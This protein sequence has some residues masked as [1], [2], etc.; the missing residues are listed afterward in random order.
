MSGRSIV[1]VVSSAL[2]AVLM[3]TGC[4]GAASRTEFEDMVRER[5]GG[6]S[7]EAVAGVLD[8]LRTRSG[9]DDPDVGVLRFNF[10]TTTAVIEVRN[11]ARPDDLDRYTYRNDQH[12]STEPVRLSADDDLDELTVALSTHPLADIERIA[13]D[14]LAAFDSDGG[15]V[16]AITMGSFGLPPAIRVDVESPRS[17]GTATFDADGQFVEFSDD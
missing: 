10:D 1:K 15:Y 17:S 12:S 5:G 11:P 9:A 16:T 6:V 4:V 2:G 14:A 7:A 8:D 13:D 3:T